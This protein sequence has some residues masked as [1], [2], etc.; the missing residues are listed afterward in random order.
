MGERTRRRIEVRGIV[1]GVG[2]RP[3]M[4]RHATSLGLVGFVGNDG[5][6]VFVEVEGA[7]AAVDRFVADV[8]AVAPP[9]A[10][11]EQVTSAPA[12]LRGE[13][14]FLIVES[15]RT[16]SASTLVSPDVAP[17][18]ACLAELHD[19][20]DR[21]YRYPFVNC[22][23]CGP[24]YSIIRALPYDR[25]LTTMAGFA[26]C[27]PCTAEY[28]DPTDRRFHAQPTC[29]PDCGPRLAVC[30]A[31]FERRS[32]SPTSSPRWSTTSAPGASWP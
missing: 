21:R 30:D 3:A 9:L 7:P 19:P 16:A 1:Q 32:R 20:A 22:T 4:H 5:H 6:G 15:D 23:D 28:H 29:C 31:A 11:V 14:E 13:R 2:F 25:P 26:M 8:E 17:C 10:L 12:P 24:R 27:E 18:A